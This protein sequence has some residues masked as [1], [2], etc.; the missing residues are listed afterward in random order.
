VNAD[1]RA[2]LPD[3]PDDLVWLEDGPSG[4]RCFEDEPPAPG[5]YEEWRRDVREANA[6]GTLLS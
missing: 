2:R 6:F 1:R 5:E 3:D 4:G